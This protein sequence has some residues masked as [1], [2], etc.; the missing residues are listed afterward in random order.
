[1]GMN[2]A[3]DSGA[4][5]V[6]TTGS[7]MGGVGRKVGAS[8][9]AVSA[10]GASIAGGFSKLIRNAVGSAFR[11]AGM[12]TGVVGRGVMALDPDQMPPPD[13]APPRH[14]VEGVRQG[15]YVVVHGLV[16]GVTGIV[17][18]PYR[19]SRK[20]G[21]AWAP[22]GILLGI[23]GAAVKSIGGALAGTSLM[24]SGTASTIGTPEEMELRQRPPRYVGPSGM[25]LP[26]SWREADG[27]A[28]LRILKSQGVALGESYVYHCYV[29]DARHFDDSG[30]ERQS[31]RAIAELISVYQKAA[32]A[33]SAAESSSEQGRAD[34]RS[35]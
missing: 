1:M 30:V 31:P 28:R 13:E 12:V 4:L 7:T 18:T 25:I 10:A 11:A 6:P 26:F 8:A 16:H 21:A 34:P 20:H 29:V 5:V 15:G 27:G 32:G 19:Y 9:S 23:T 22:L 17:L 33:Q 2:A 35:M 24:L 14:V 3:D